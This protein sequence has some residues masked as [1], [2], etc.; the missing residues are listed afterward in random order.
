MLSWIRKNLK[1][2]TSAGLRKTV[3]HGKSTDIIVICEI[4]NTEEIKIVTAYR[5]EHYE[6]NI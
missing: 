2:N 3:Y 6:N 1:M 5:Q 4:R